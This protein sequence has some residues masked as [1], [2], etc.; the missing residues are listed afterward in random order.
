M[1]CEKCTFSS[2]LHFYPSLEGL[3]GVWSTL[4]WWKGFLPM[5]KLSFKGFSSPAP[6]GFCD[7]S[8]NVGNTG[9]DEPWGLFQAQF[10]PKSNFHQGRWS[11]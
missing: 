7:S 4:G 10:E 2:V 8:R 1:A 5:A 9:W 11:R 6:Q 3:G